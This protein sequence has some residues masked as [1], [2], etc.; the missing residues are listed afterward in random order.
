MD[1]ILTQVFQITQYLSKKQ[2]FFGKTKLTVEILLSVFLSQN[3]K[4][5]PWKSPREAVSLYRV[6]QPCK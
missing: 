4:N 5:F 1:G 2:V 3:A 6:L